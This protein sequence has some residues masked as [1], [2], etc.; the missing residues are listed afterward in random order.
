MAKEIQTYFYY[1]LNW[2]LY[3]EKDYNHIN[4]FSVCSCLDC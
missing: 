4:R 2:N 3:S 1:A